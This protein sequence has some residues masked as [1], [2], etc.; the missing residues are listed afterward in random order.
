MERP[1]LDDR[2]RIAVSACLIGENVRYDGT[3][4][5]HDFVVE[6]LNRIFFLVAICPEVAVGLGLPR[7]PIQLVE[8][9]GVIKACGVERPEMDVTERLRQ[10]GEHLAVGDLSDICGYVFKSRSPSCGLVT[11][12]L[13]SGFSPGIFAKEMLDH[14]SLLPV[15]EDDDLTQFDLQC[16]FIDHVYAYQRW[17]R[18]IAAGVDYA[19]L[20]AFHHHNRFIL[21]AHGMTGLV[22]LDK[23]MAQGGRHFES[24]L[25]EYGSGY[26]A[27]SRRL[28]SLSNHLRVLKLVLNTLEVQAGVI[29]LRLRQAIEGCAAAEGRV[30]R[31][32]IAKALRV[33]RE[34]LQE[35]EVVDLAQQVYFYP[36][37]EEKM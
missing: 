11:P 2:P 17:M 26:M 36:L 6:R 33:I 5:Q 35:N 30:G 27:H 25:M 22:A 8:Q 20:Q 18:F 28:A 23:L 13:P 19:A 16:Q 31:E 29:I 9:K 10:Y 32:K 37:A 21:M 4:K 12:V 24:L 1:D 34:W 15:V 3:N 14:L 7:A